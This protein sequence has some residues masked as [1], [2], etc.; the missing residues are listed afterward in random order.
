MLAVERRIGAPPRPGTA[1]FRPRPTVGAAV[2]T[3]RL[4]CEERPPLG[5]AGIPLFSPLDATG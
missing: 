3:W 1:S 2:E 5:T 4:R